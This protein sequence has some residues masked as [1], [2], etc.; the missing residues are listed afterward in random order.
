M[1]VRMYYGSLTNGLEM[2]SDEILRILLSLGN[3]KL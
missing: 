2:V 1:T 3:I